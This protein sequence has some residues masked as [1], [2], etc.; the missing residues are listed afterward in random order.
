ML[1]LIL[2]VVSCSAGTPSL[3]VGY[4]MHDLLPHKRKYGTGLV[5]V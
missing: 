2:S 3:F 5:F 1:P 4:C